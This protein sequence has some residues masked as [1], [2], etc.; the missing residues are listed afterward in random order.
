MSGSTPAGGHPF[1]GRDERPDDEGLPGERP[2]SDDERTVTAPGEGRRAGETG[3]RAAQGPMDDDIDAPQPSP[4][5]PEQ[6]DAPSP[7][8]AT[9]GDPPGGST[10]NQTGRTQR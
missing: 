1:G 8:D 2:L 7:A 6:V 5:I 9:E 4:G 10:A 3:S